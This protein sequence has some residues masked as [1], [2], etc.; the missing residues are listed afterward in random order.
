MPVVLQRFV[1]IGQIPHV[2]SV[3]RPTLYSPTTQVQSTS[4]GSGEDRNPADNNRQSEVRV[5]FI[6]I[7]TAVCSVARCM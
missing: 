4:G 3:P 2:T 6:I 7:F 1:L 5:S